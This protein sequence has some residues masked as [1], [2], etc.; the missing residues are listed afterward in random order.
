MHGFHPCLQFL[1]SE[2]GSYLSMRQTLINSEAP[3][4]RMINKWICA[5]FRHLTNQPTSFLNP[6]QWPIDREKPE[7]ASPNTIIVPQH[8]QAPWSQ[9]Q[10]FNEPGLRPSSHRSK[11]SLSSRY[12]SSAFT[13]A[14]PAAVQVCSQASSFYFQKLTRGGL[15]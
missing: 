2:S 3:I 14:L 15:R 10:A 5:I 12:V 9:E 6:F 8:P 4:S 7:L 13:A 11:V 1:R